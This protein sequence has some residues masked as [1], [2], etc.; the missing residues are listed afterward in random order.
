MRPPI[1]SRSGF[2]AMLRRV[3]E[4]SS[5]VSVGY[6]ADTEAMEVQFRQGEVYAFSGVPRE[7]YEALVTADSPGDFFNSHVRD[8]FPATRQS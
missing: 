8:A 7:T 1:G 5:I 6:D 4:S 3:I 2:K